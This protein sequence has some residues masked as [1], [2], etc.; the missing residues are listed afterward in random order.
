MQFHVQGEISGYTKNYIEAVIE[1]V[2]IILDCKVED[3]LLNGV[4]HSTSFLLTLSV[5]EVYRCKLSA[6]NERD[7]QQ[8]RKLN[9]D[10]LIIDRDI[11][12]LEGANGK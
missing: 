6:L 2:A 5:K 8:L 4:R 10:Y 1:T 3:I 11:I 12:S 9:I 7:R